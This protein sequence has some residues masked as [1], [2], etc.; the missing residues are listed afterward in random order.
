MKKVVFAIFVLFSA[1]LFIHAQRQNFRCQTLTSHDIILTYYKY[2]DKG[3]KIISRNKNDPN[4]AKDATLELL[5]LFTT[6]QYRQLCIEA[7]YTFI[8]EGADYMYN[9]FAFKNKISKQEYFDNIDY[10]ETLYRAYLI[11][12]SNLGISV[13]IPK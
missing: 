10:L 9:N 13:S 11:I 12:A 1:S 6:Q 8:T 7:Q 2:Q 4:D 5:N 3:F